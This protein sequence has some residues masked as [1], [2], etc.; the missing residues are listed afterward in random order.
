MGQKVNPHGLRVGIIKDWQTQWYADKKDFGKYLLEDH[1]LRE[2]IKKEYYSCGI[3][4]VSIQRLT[5]AKI[6]INIET[7][8]PGMLIGQKGAGVEEMKKKLAKIAPDKSLSLNIMEVK[9]PDTDA[10]LVAENVAAQLE[11]RAS[12]RQVR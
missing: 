5:G 9:R 1:K 4:S 7:S 3:S 10:I 6:V 11:K 8:R 12:W 2:F